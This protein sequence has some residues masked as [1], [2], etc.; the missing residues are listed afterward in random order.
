MAIEHDP[1]RDQIAAEMIEEA[2]RVFSEDGTAIL[3]RD[4]LNNYRY[5]FIT[6]ARFALYKALYNLKPNY[7]QVGRWLNKDH[8][9]VMY[10]V[11]VAERRM[12]TDK[13]FAQAVWRITQFGRNRLAE[14]EADFVTS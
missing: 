11:P 5:R 14:I 4:L 10:G 13:E 3:A 2:A 7:M 8:T 9:S 6:T 1:I 12:Q